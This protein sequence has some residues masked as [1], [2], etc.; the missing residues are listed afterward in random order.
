[1]AC[2][3]IRWT[4]MDDADPPEQPFGGFPFFGDLS[5]LLGGMGDGGWGAAKQLA[6]AMATEGVSEPNVEPTTRIEIEQ[7]ARVA[8]LQIVETTGLS[9]HSGGLEIT[10]VTRAQWA[11]RA[12]NA[13]KPIFERLTTALADG[14]GPGPAEVDSEFGQDAATAL[15]GQMMGMLAPMMLSM[16]AGSMVG[17]LAK[18]SLGQYDIPIPRAG[19]EILIVPAN[20]DEFGNEWS[21]ES[22]DLRLWV[23]LHEIA[24]HLVLGVP[25]VG[26]SLTSM[27]LEYAGGFRA[28]PSALE[29]RLSGLDLSNPAA[30]ND[31]QSTLGD[32]EV[33]LGAIQSPEQL[34][35]KPR[36]EALTSLVVGVVD[37]TMDLVGQHLLGSYGQLTEAL[38][39]RRVEADPSDRFIERML[40]LELTQAQYDRGAAFVA[41]VVERAGTDGLSRLWEDQQMLPT[42]NEVDA[43]GLWLARI[44]LPA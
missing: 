27:L 20:I 21:L 41:G 19:D 34:T 22:Q 17:H 44:D 37:H 9:P 35:L 18:R 36:L 15:F 38:R 26:G 28:D 16:T 13:Y 30:L 31:L 32:P 33:I 11:D 40:G 29:E 2:S 23:C 12:L 7:L 43:P 14:A 24:H 3:R 1:M 4:A 39:R 8:E 6:V 25:H 10:A 42:P 5:G